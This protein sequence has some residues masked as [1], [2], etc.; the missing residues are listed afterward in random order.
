[1]LRYGIPEANPALY[2]RLSLGVT[3]PLNILAGIPLYAAAA[4]WL[5]AGA[6]GM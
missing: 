3:F 1:M 2:F 5:L 6:P 4:K